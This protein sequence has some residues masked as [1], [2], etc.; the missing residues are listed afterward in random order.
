[1]ECNP[2]RQAT[3]ADNRSYRPDTYIVSVTPTGGRPVKKMTVVVRDFA[4]LAIIYAR[5]IPTFG[6]STG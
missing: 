4:N 1:M 5:Q 2:S 3:G 6:Q